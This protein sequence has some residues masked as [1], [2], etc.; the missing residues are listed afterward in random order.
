MAKFVLL[1]SEQGEEYLINFEHVAMV[2]EIREHHCKL[3]IT[4][5]LEININGKSADDLLHFLGAFSTDVGGTPLTI[6]ENCFK[7]APS[8]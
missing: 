6:G 4:R 3:V 2:T 5:D 8:G 7:R 1:I